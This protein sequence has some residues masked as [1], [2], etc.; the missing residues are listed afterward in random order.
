MVMP[1]DASM[2][3]VIG[4]RSATPIAADSPGR[5]PITIPIVTPTIMAKIF[6][7]ITAFRKPPPI[8]DSVSNIVFPLS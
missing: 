4:R 2:E 1:V 7:D 8:S 5:Q 6:I 3:N